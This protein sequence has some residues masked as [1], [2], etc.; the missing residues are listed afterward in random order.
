MTTST[1]IVDIYVP[2]KQNAD[3]DGIVD[4]VST[5]WWILWKNLNRKKMLCLCAHTIKISLN[6]WQHQLR[7]LF[8]KNI[9][10]TDIKF[11]IQRCRNFFYCPYFLFSY[12][13]FFLSCTWV[14]GCKK[15]TNLPLFAK[16]NICTNNKF[17]NFYA[18][19]A[20]YSLPMKT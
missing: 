3:V 4:V 18:A 20:Y 13:L 11:T 2:K 16:E 12:I 14:W 5:V 15:F 6:F 19:A 1:Y 9:K 7:I 10:L 8:S 17:V